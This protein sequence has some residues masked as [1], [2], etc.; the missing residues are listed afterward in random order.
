MEMIRPMIWT[1]V[2]VASSLVWSGPEASAA[3]RKSAKGVTSAWMGFLGDQ[4]SSSV[5]APF[6]GRLENAVALPTEGPGFRR[7][8]RDRYYG[9]HETIA[10]LKWAGSRRVEAYPGTAPMLVGDISEKPGGRVP[11]HRSHRTGRDAD[12]A[13]FESGNV[14]RAHFK[15]NL[16]VHE[17]DMDK[18]W[19]LIE[20]LLST[21]RVQYIFVNRRLIPHLVRRARRFGW[22]ERSIKKIFVRHKDKSRG[23][24]IRHASG[25]TYHFHV[26]FYCPAG[27][28][29][30]HD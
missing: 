27:D 6:D 10:M 15:G 8:D 26:R 1:L 7:R 30:C 11:P 5:G 12:I 18:S 17:I 14:D 3:K 19:F 4:V 16:R 25:H 23:A 20:T 24:P 21:G 29:T 28:E 22:S 13:F 9:T 2:L